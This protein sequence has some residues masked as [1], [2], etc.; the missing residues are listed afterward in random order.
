MKDNPEL[1]L[2]DLR[3]MI[4]GNGDVFESSEQRIFIWLEHLNLGKIFFLS[5]SSRD[6]NHL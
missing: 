6:F 3:L 2:N 4:M 1:L 5:P